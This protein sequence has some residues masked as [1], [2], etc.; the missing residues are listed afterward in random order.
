MKYTIILLAL[1]G[2]TLASCSETTGTKISDFANLSFSTNQ[3]YLESKGFLCKNELADSKSITCISYD[4]SI[5][6]LGR[7]VAEKIVN[8]DQNGHVLSIAAKLQP[9][10]ASLKESLALETD[11]SAVYQEATDMKELVRPEGG[12]KH[13]RRPDG[14]LIRLAT[15][16]LG[17]PGLM[18]DSVM[19]VAFPDIPKK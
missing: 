8:F 19:L 3:K 5:E 12:L 18:D 7:A 17:L 16:R 14:S 2:L 11:L 10:Y 1:A 13:W 6:V 15:I 9:K 4:R